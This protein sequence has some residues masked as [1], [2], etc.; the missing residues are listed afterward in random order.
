MRD[1]C[2][3]TYQVS[4]ITSFGI[5]G[6]ALVEYSNVRIKDGQAIADLSKQNYI[7]VTNFLRLEGAKEQFLNLMH[8]EYLSVYLTSVASKAKSLLGHQFKGNVIIEL[9]K[10]KR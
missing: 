2:S 3:S 8:S 4:F 7:E 6:N 9:T 10:L 1:L 5:L